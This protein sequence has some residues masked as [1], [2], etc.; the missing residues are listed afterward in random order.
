MHLRRNG[1]YTI[2]FP[3]LRSAIQAQV[4][5]LRA[6]AQVQTF[7]PNGSA[8]LRAE[9]PIHDLAPALNGLR[10][11]HISDLHLK[12]RWG[13]GYTELLDRL[14]ADPPDLILITGDFIDNKSDH[15]PTL[16]I[17]ERLIGHL[18]A[19]HGIYAILGNHD[20]EVVRPYI[21]A[22]GVRFV[23]HR[24]MIVSAGKGEVEF[25]GLPGLSRHELDMDFIRA[26][27]PRAP[28]IPRIILSHYPDLFCS[29]RGSDPDLYLA[30]HTH[31]GQICLPN[32]T[33]VVT[34]D[35][36]PRRFC[37][38]IHRIGKTWYAV[39]S[40]FGF[41]SLPLRMFCPTEVV[42]FVFRLEP[43]PS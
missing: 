38:G 14:R 26:L 5:T 13:R 2:D 43:N 23:T 1:R 21:A 4:Q 40:G 35:V 36:M 28:G 17:L 8:Y 41:T 18:T 32:G 9:I 3:A 11:I 29:V 24:R 6:G 19:R 33:P 25:I 12:P 42:E 30:G 34:H 16:P 39:S 31:G 22:M 37:K 27:P 15:R 10:V 20:P 7:V